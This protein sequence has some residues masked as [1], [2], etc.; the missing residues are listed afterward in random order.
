MRSR[1]GGRL[2]RAWSVSDLPLRASLG[3][4]RL[5]HPLLTLG[6]LL[7]GRAEDKTGESLVGELCPLCQ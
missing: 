3:F 2:G 4:T 5:P 1:A 6:L 7:K